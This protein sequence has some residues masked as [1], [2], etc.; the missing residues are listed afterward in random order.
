MKAATPT[1]LGA[2]AEESDGA[3]RARRPQLAA[4]LD[5][6][7]KSAIAKVNSYLDE[8]DRMQKNWDVMDKM[9]LIPEE[10]RKRGHPRISIDEEIVRYGLENE[11]ALS[12]AEKF[13][14]F[15]DEVKKSKVAKIK[16][17]KSGEK[18]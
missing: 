17:R 3:V 10:A 18:S 1:R 2:P 14:A 8:A 7:K 15:L 5:E 4:N 11:F 16:N 6:I 12:T 9:G 13:A